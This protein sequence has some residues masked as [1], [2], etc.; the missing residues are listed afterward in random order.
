MSKINYILISIILLSTCTYNSQTS[1]LSF[2][3][4]VE[5]NSDNNTFKEEKNT[6]TYEVS[7]PSLAENPDFCKI[8][9]KTPWSTSV[10]FPISDNRIN[11]NGVINVQVIFLDFPDLEGTRTKD[12]LLDFFE[13]Y[14]LGV[15]DFFE[16][17]SQSK[18]TFDWR[19]HTEFIRIP[20]LLSSLNLKREYIYAADDVDKTLR[21]GITISDSVIDYTDIDMVVV[22]INPDV[23]KDIANIS[24]AWP[25]VYPWGIKTEEKTIYNATFL[26]SDGFNPKGHTTVSHEIGHLFGLADLYK[27]DWLEDN[28]TGNYN[29]VIQFLGIFDFMNFAFTDYY[30]KGDNRDMMGWQKWQLSW[31]E[32]SQV[33]CL[34]ANKPFKSIQI[35]TPVSDS[36]DGNKI[37]IIKLS[38][39][40]VIV[41][42]KRSKNIYCELC[43]G[44]IYTYTVDST[45]EGGK[46]PIKMIRPSNSTMELFEDA[47][48]NQDEYLNFENINIKVLFKNDEK[49]YLS[50]IIE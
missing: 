11:N 19:I 29:K 9:S 40:K 26:A 49:T 3:S 13:I 24:P 17:Q 21:K 45:I 43:S 23:P 37:I 32:D 44:G 30:G 50:L 39:S 18:V 33:V 34:D 47:F 2:V 8:A 14:S 41:I 36:I 1:S 35:L 28:P 31:I 7:D 4:S 48:I 10:G 15:N 22:V 38:E 42:E 5:L 16:R 6:P 20:D 12:Q 46:G 25:L 27:Y